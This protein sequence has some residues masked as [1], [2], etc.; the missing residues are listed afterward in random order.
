[1][2]LFGIIK[3]Y[4]VCDIMKFKKGDKVICSKFYY[5]DRDHLNGEIGVFKGY[6]KLADDKT[7]ALVKYKRFAGIFCELSHTELAHNGQLMF[8]FMY[9][10]GD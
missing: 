2:L 4:K 7:V 1:M 3:Y 10:N 6:R 9:E 8:S 5:S